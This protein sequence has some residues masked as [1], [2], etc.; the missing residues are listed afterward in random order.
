MKALSLALRQG[1]FIILNVPGY[2]RLPSLKSG[3][4][5]FFVSNNLRNPYHDITRSGIYAKFSNFKYLNCNFSLYFFD[6]FLS[7]LEH[8]VINIFS[9]C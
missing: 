4:L 6:Q 2:Y 9:H 3:T 5:Y 8:L 1:I 7:H